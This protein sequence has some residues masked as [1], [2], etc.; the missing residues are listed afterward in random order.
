MLKL[1]R[2]LF[3]QR[4]PEVPAADIRV[5]GGPLSDRP[6]GPRNL[7]EPEIA[8]IHSSGTCPFCASPKG[9][10]E[11]PRGGA[12]INLFCRNVDCD[13]RFNVVDLKFG[14]V[15]VG[16]FTGACPAEF[17]EALRD[18]EASAPHPLRH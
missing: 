4:P 1:L 15:P 10:A 14:Y 16:Q 7:T 3:G 2:K 18:E 11:G 17:I 9:L 6:S 5:V 12:S 8:H 13:S